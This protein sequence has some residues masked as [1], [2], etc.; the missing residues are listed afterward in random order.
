MGYLSRKG[1]NDPEDGSEVGRAVTLPRAHNPE[2]IAQEP[3]AHRSG[4]STVS[5]VGSREIEATVFQLSER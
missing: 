5:L 1:K 3:R 4:S 2:H